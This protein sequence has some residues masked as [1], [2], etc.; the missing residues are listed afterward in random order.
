VQDRA[1][2]D[3]VRELVHQLAVEPVPA[4]SSGLGRYAA[5]VLARLE[6]MA[7]TRRIAELKARLQRLNPVENVEEFNRLFGRMIGLEQHRRTLR[8]RGIGGL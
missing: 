3:R 4:A 8:D 2:D 1:A 6:E 5:E 7:T